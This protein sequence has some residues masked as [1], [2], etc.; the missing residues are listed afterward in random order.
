M[1]VLQFYQ[2]HGVF[3]PMSNE[4]SIHIYK[5]DIESF[6]ISYQDSKIIIFLDVTNDLLFYQT[7]LKIDQLFQMLLPIFQD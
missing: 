1:A 7:D 2:S 6:N 4:F 3:I 5:S